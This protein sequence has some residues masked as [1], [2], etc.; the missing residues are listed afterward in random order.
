MNYLIYL[1]I[2]KVLSI[3]GIS[4]SK[5]SA[6]LAKKHSYIIGESRL[7]PPLVIHFQIHLIHPQASTG[8]NHMDEGPAKKTGEVVGLYNW[9]RTYHWNSVYPELLYYSSSTLML[10]RL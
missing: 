10:N 7:S 5:V 3:H 1:F 8:L 6:S 9:R 2:Y 4:S